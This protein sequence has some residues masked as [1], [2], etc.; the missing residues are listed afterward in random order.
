VNSTP[1]KGEVIIKATWWSQATLRSVWTV[2]VEEKVIWRLWWTCRPYI[3]HSSN[4]CC[5]MNGSPGDSS[6]Q[7][8]CTYILKLGTNSHYSHLWRTFFQKTTRS[9][10]KRS[11]VLAS[12]QI[13]ACKTEHL[14]VIIG[15]S[16]QPVILSNVLHYYSSCIC[17]YNLQNPYLIS[18]SLDFSQ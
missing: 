15:S 5:L 17:Q 4:Q 16:S 18:L 11:S 3:L 14:N 8:R 2:I 9:P 13:V 7:Q 12:S 1:I 6:R 10:Q